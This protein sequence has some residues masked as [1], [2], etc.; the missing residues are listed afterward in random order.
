MA[1]AAFSVSVGVEL[2]FV[3]LWC[4]FFSLSFLFLAVVPPFRVFNVRDRLFFS[5]LGLRGAVPVILAVFPM[6]AGLGNARLFFN[7]AFFV[8]LVSL[9]LQG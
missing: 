8:V 3:M 2:W 6:L 5:W 9:L 7:V 1:C 4:F